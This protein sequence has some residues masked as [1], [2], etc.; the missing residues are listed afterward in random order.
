MRNEP[1]K[2]MAVR[3]INFPENGDAQLPSIPQQQKAALTNASAL[4]QDVAKIVRDNGLSKKFGTGPKEHVFVEGWLT[5]SRVNN[6]APHSKIEAVETHGEFEVIKARAWITDASG[7]VVSEADGYCSNEENNWKGKPFYAR[8]SMA[9][10]RAIGKAM[11]LRHAWVMVMAGFS[12]TPAEEMDGVQEDHKPTPA[13]AKQT[14]KNYVLKNTPGPKEGD[15]AEKVPASVTDAAAPAS[16]PLVVPDKQEEGEAVM[17]KAYSKAKTD[18]N[19]KEYRG[20]LF[21]HSDNS[22]KWWN[23]YHAETI[24]KLQSL[25][26]SVVAARLEMKGEYPL[27]NEVTQ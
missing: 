22:E 19:G 24:A 15:D 16:E 18:K 3:V 11:R 9:Q 17:L 5:I 14:A 21:V 12:P 13:P 8:A 25:K 4:A 6:E 23:C 7:A 26:G 10:T 27:C 2:E 20:I 1:E